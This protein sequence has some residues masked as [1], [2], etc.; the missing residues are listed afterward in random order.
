M[1]VFSD[2]A[3]AI[4]ALVVAATTI[5]LNVRDCHVLNSNFEN[6]VTLHELALNLLCF[7]SSVATSHPPKGYAQPTLT[8]LKMEDGRYWITTNIVYKRML[9]DESLFNT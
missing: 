8:S 7:F 4:V 2:F 3:H 1:P 6:D 5:K 9:M